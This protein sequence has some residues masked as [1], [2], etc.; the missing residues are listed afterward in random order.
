MLEFIVSVLPSDGFHCLGS[1]SFSKCTVKSEQR[2]VHMFVLL[3]KKVLQS[4]LAMNT[5][6]V[7]GDSFSYHFWFSLFLTISDVLEM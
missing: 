6:V 1:P 3:F 2:T 4:H 5:V 7:F